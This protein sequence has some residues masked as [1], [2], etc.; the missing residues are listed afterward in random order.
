MLSFFNMKIKKIVII[1]I[2]NIFLIGCV[3]E[4]NST[5]SSTNRFISGTPS[6][7]NLSIPLEIN[8]VEFNPGIPSNPKNYEK[9]G[10][11]PELRRAESRKFSNDL[12]KSLARTN[13]FGNIYIT[14]NQKY[15]SD[16][17]INGKIIKSNGEDLHIEIS[18][19]DSTG[20]KLIKNKIYKHRTNEEFYRNLRNKG[21]DPFDKLFD[22]ISNDLIKSLRSKDLYNIQQITE[23]RFAREMDMTNFKESVVE[24]NN[25]VYANFIPAANDPLFLRAKNIRS[26]D[27]LFRSNMQSTYDQFI[28]EMDASYDI[29][30]KAS[31]TAAQKARKA[32]TAS[33]LKGIAG[34]ALL[35]AGAVAMAD[36]GSGY[37]YDAGA[38]TTG[39]VGALAG[40]AL[41]DQ[42]I[43]D[44]QE[45]KIHKETINEVSKSFDGNIAPKVIELEGKT[46]TLDGNLS[47]QFIKW[48]SLLKEIYVEE[49]STIQDINIL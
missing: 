12:K 41:F 26:K 34:A 18:A 27:L 35:I 42:A 5:L 14:P 21:K 15:L 47:Q 43:S 49:N 48:Q 13:E 6:T 1:L 4:T 25:I 40:A 7:V 29:W 20:S 30:Q 36:S 22:D 24:K 16:L 9:E 2:A 11:W 23:L 17:A 8:I 31:F 3:A 46:V 33:T 37:N 38:Y 32:K 28:Q 44:N 39:F 45:A 19:I 10:V